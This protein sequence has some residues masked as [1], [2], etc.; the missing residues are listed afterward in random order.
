MT[1]R[2]G[3][4]LSGCGVKD[5]SEIHEAVMA[6]YHVVKNG[7]TPVF[8]APNIEQ[9]SVINHKNDTD[10]REHRNVLVESARIAR[11]DIHDIADI[12]IGDVDALIF[13]GG[14]GAAKNLSDMA[15]HDNVADMVVE[16]HTQQL[17][18]EMFEARKPMGFICIA[19]ASIA[20][21]ALKGKGVK[22]TI[23]NDMATAKNIMALGNTHVEATA[24]DIVV[25]TEKKIV[26]TPAYMLAQN[27]VEAGEGIGKLV[28]RIFKL[29]S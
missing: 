20:A 14:F 3:I 5:G 18:E 26:S 8:M 13:P 12:R 25:D 16:L 29:T 22:L 24:G 4:V 1:K 15:L 10:M 27:I 19:P 28:D 9:S 17:I 23:G 11:G 7:G 6:L 2:I 21:V